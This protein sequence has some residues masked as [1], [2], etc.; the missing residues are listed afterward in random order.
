MSAPSTPAPPP[1]PAPPSP[2]DRWCPAVFGERPPPPEICSEEEQPSS[3]LARSDA[4]GESG[5]GA[6][7]RVCKKCGEE[8]AVTNFALKGVRMRSGEQ[9]RACVCNICKRV[10]DRQLHQL[11]KTVGP[12][13]PF[14]EIC[15]RLGRVVLDHDHETG[16]FRGWLC[17]E[18]NSGLGKLGDD[19]A[20]IRRALAYLERSMNSEERARS[21]SPRRRGDSGGAA[22]PY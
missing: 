11:H 9:Y 3:D 15:R 4:S 16:E 8:R 20:G 2:P 19:I 17:Q 10:Y 13:S 5:G 22:A 12:P 6:G 21:R 7:E 14:C 1:S 18:C